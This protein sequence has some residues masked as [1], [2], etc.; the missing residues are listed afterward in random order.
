MKP[1]RL[2]FGVEDERHIKHLESEFPT[3]LRARQG[4]TNFHNIQIHRRTTNDGQIGATSD[5][6][7]ARARLT[8]PSATS[9]DGAS[10][11]SSR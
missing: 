2:D 7:S 10:V 8:G 5:C 4:K 1:V 6:L 3:S 11:S 9:R